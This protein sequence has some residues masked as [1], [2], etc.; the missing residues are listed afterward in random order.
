MVAVFVLGAATLGTVVIN[1]KRNAMKKMSGSMFEDEARR[2]A[3]AKERVDG[4]AKLLEEVNARANAAEERL[5]AA[6]R[7]KNAIER[8]LEEMERAKAN[9]KV[10][11]MELRDSVTVL[12]NDLN[13]AT[14]R[15]QMVVRKW[16]DELVTY[17]EKSPQDFLAEVIGLVSD[18]DNEVTIEVI[19]P[20]APRAAKVHEEVRLEECEWEYNPRLAVSGFDAL[21]DA[22]QQR[23]C[24]QKDS[25]G[26]GEEGDGRQT[27]RLASQSDDAHARG[28]RQAHQHR[29]ATRSRRRSQGG[30]LG[31]SQPRGEY[32]A[33][34]GSHRPIVR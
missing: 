21:V 14:E 25:R 7:E 6:M 13:N 29:R 5:E 22:R 24:G 12:K 28:A 23:A 33:A 18:M 3:A 20:E 1:V 26:E 16:R 4:M 34:E 17:R 11:N 32:P 15:H 8:V 27:R 30:S 2:A 10:E 9:M 19:P 31:A